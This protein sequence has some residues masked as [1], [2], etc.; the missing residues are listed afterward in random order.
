MV[1]LAPIES[2][3]G[4]WTPLARKSPSLDGRIPRVYPGDIPSFFAF[5]AERYSGGVK[6]NNWDE[7]QRQSD[8]RVLLYE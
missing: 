1:A 2:V 6:K 4:G 5:L 7:L 3:A 8:E